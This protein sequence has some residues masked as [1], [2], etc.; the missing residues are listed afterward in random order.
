MFG[1]NKKDKK[2]KKRNI[3]RFIS[4]AAN[5]VPVEAVNFSIYKNDAGSPELSVRTTDVCE[6]LH[7]SHIDFE[8][9]TSL[10]RLE[11]S[12]E[13]KEAQSEKHFKV[14]IYEITDYNQ[15]FI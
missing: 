11:V 1:R 13:F 2:K 5:G 9:K 6:A 8:L 7:Y 12:A 3:E 15:F 10:K 14:Y 4:L